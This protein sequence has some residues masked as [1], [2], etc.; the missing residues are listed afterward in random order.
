[1][2]EGCATWTHYTI[3]NRMFEKGLITE[4]SMLE[5]MHSHS[6]VVMQPALERPPLLGP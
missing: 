4:G 1:M 3:L 5:F 6:S 2:N